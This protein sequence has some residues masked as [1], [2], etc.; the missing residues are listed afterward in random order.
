[1]KGVAMTCNTLL[2]TLLTLP[3]DAPL[4]FETPEGEIGNGYHVTEFKLA[5][6]TG[7]DCGARLSNWSEATLQLLDGEG[8]GH[9]PAGK[10]AGILKQSIDR[11]SGLGD[12]PLQVEFAH[13]NKARQIYRLATP[14]LSAGRVLVGLRDTRAHCKPA[15]D[16]KAALG[17]AAGCCGA[18]A[19]EA[20]GCCQ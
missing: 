5:H 11:V 2:E 6:V 18:N 12:A 13:G 10:F 16:R 3:G 7:I 15:L 8:G 14:E 4:V 1:M 9:M 19:A 20:T 17:S